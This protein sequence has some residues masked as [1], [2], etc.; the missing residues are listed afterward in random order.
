MDI[1]DDILKITVKEHHSNDKGGTVEDR[2]EEEN[3]DKLKDL[4]PIGV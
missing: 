2:Y 1:D 3:K 4:I